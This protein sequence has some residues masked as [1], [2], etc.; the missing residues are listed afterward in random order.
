MTLDEEDIEAIAK[1]LARLL[2]GETPSAYRL[3][4]PKELAAALHVSPDYVYT[5]AVELGVMRLGDGPKAR[6]RF[7]LH[8]AQQAMRSR[9]QP[10]VAAAGRR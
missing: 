7:D 4:S 5:H 2:G 8:T 6:L 10:P 3:L 9:K 1:R